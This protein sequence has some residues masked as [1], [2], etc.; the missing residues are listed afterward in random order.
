MGTNSLKPAEKMSA[1]TEA[2][3]PNLLE[4]VQAK[5]QEIAESVANKPIQDRLEAEKREKDLKKECANLEMNLELKSNICRKLQSKVNELSTEVVELRTQ[6][7]K[8]K[9]MSEGYKNKCVNAMK[10]QELMRVE[11]KKLKEYV[12]ELEEKVK[13]NDLP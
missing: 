7:E 5:I 13:E 1:E 12:R 2:G 8:E 4:T 10:D 3:E 11:L 6:L 9:R